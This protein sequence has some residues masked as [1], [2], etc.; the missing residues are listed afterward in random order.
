MEKNNMLTGILMLFVIIILGL[1]FI[2]PVAN[3]A[4][5][6]DSLQ[7]VTLENVTTVPAAGTAGGQVNATTNFNVSGAQS[8]WRVSGCPLSGVTLQNTTG[9]VYTVT[10]DYVFNLNYGNFTLVN[11]AKVNQSV[12]SN[13]ITVVNYTHCDAGYSTDSATRSITSLIQ[14]F[15]IIA[16]IVLCAVWLKNNTSVFD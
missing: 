6:V 4:D 16:L 1:T 5:K 9:T 10:T 15:M 3:T 2:Q 12:L 7:T 13:N 8:D 11:T 14:T